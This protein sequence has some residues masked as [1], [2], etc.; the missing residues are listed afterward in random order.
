MIHSF[1]DF[2]MAWY[3]QLFTNLC[4]LGLFC[5]VKCDSEDIV[6]FQRYSIEGKV[7]LPFPS[8]QEWISSTRIIADGGRYLGFLK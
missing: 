8:E 1:K 6:E 2:K 4:I 7:L 5:I 3:K